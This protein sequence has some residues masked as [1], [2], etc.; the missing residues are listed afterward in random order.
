[1]NM[2][3]NSDMPQEGGTHHAVL[4]SAKE[5]QMQLLLQ[6]AGQLGQAPYTYTCIYT[7]GCQ[8]LQ[9]CR[10]L[11]PMQVGALPAQVSLWL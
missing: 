5:P 10:P 7:A 1:M 3:V 6:L 9:A 8:V 11:A 4:W 2:I